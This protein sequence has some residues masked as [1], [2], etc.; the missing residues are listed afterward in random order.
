ML[1]AFYGGLAAGVLLGLLIAFAVMTRAP[2][3]PRVVVIGRDVR[4]SARPAI[5][6][7]RSWPWL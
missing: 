6:R 2:R 7:K 1:A 4:V 3:L 5:A